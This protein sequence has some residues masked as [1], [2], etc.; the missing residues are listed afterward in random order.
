MQP[1]IPETPAMQV[2]V[3]QLHDVT[4]R[5]RKRNSCARVEGVPPEEFGI[6][7]NARNIRDS[8][9]CFHEVIR[10]EADLIAEGFDAEQVRK[11]PGRGERH[12]QEAIARDTVDEAHGGARSGDGMNKANREILVTEHYVRMDYEGDGKPALYR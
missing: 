5:V 1:L 4:I 12:T 10:R 8:G 2:S 11:L 6:A 9:Y 3:P 7:R